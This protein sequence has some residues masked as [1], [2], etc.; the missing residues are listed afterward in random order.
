V[1]DADG[2]VTKATRTITD[3]DGSKSDARARS[4]G[5]TYDGLDRLVSST[6]STG[7]KNTYSYDPAGNRTG[8]TR[9]GAKDGNFS[10]SASFSDANQLLRSETTGS[11]RGVG[12]GVASYSYDAAGMRT[13]QSV[14]GVGTSYTY[15]PTG[16]TSQVSRDG[17]S[18][19]YAYDGL[20]RQAS[21]TDET[22]YG[23]QTT[24]NTFDGSRRVQESDDLHGTI[25]IVR[26]AA[27]NLAAHVASSGEATWDLLDGLGSVVAG[28]AGLSVTQLGWY[29]DWGDL[30]L[31]S[32]GW[33]SPVGFTGQSQD[34]TQGLVHNQARSY[35]TGTGSWTAADTW[36]GL[37]VQ[38]KSLSRYGY[39]WDNPVT[40]VDPDGHQCAKRG[41]GDA[42]PLGCGAPPHQAYENV[43]MPERASSDAT[44]KP[45][46]PKPTEPTSQ[47]KNSERHELTYTNY[48]VPTSNIADPQNGG[49]PAGKVV[50]K[51]PYVSPQ[52]V[53]KTIVDQS[54]RR[55]RFG[56]ECAELCQLAWVQFGGVIVDAISFAPGAFA[57][58]VSLPLGG[59]GCVNLDPE[60][61]GSLLNSLYDWS[62]TEQALWDEWTTNK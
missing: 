9:S 55:M 40:Y 57:C 25:S 54:D 59:P 23:T 35:D 60:A 5:Y 56:F 21:V 30:N 51:S 22:R 19:S 28:A 17:R 15:D 53:D 32:D 43:N 37:L 1:Y 58:G 38:P 27:G 46:K 20:G 3:G 13:T 45:A 62:R 8:W 11:G 42:L 33:S 39:V 61:G 34:L 48:V 47:N 50:V 41:P 6:T 52:C 4:V 31:E 2:N 10:Q 16:R 26:D 7:E 24:T 18:T 36:A 44:T 29:E 49:C 12:G 14:G